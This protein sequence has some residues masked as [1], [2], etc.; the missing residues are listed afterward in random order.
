MKLL[1][2]T[3]DFEL[4]DEIRDRFTRRVE[5]AL[6]AYASHIEDIQIYV[7]DL[8]GPKG[9]VDK[10]CQL[11]VRTRQSGELALREVAT[12]F[13]AALSRASRRMKHRLSR[14]LSVN[15][16][17]PRETIRTSEAVA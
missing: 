11:A 5:L 13:D 10:L 8:N 12:T 16:N 14:T 1:I 9:G 17:H 4:T 3:R 2:R 7:M 6:D 15:E